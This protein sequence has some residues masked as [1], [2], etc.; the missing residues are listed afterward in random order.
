MITWKPEREDPYLGWIKQLDNI[1]AG[2]QKSIERLEAVIFRF[3]TEMHRFDILQEAGFDIT[4]LDA[5]GE[6]LNQEE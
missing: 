3:A 6:I 4:I 1:V 5:D 2:H